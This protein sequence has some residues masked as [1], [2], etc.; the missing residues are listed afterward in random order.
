MPL[1]RTPVAANRKHED[2]LTLP[3]AVVTLGI[4]SVIVALGVEG[5]GGIVVRA[6]GLA[7]ATEV[8]GE[9]RA[10]RSYATM[11]RETVRV[12]FDMDRA[13]IRTELPDLPGRVL[14]ELDLKER[15]VLL[16]NLSAGSAVLFYS[17]GRAATPTTI[18]LKNR[19]DERWR[20]TVSITG[21]VT[22]Q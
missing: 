22:I 1:D 5:L 2:G 11:R 21:R 16:E 14:H 12:T 20:L 19:R 8:A 10:A 13:I 15:N 4:I 7:A 6:Q 9:L 17:T 3:E 18:T